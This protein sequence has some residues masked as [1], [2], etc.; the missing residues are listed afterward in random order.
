MKIS[1][2]GRNDKRRNLHR[3][4][5]DFKVIKEALLIE[6][7]FLP[8]VEMTKPELTRTQNPQLKNT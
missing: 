8:V 2:V 6:R 3:T 4:K 7:R 5:Q 1:P